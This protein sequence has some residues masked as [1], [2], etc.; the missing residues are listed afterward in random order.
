[1]SKGDHGFKKKPKGASGGGYA[2]PRVQIG[3]DKVTRNIITTWAKQNNRSFAS[4]VREL[5]NIG[6]KVR[7]IANP[8]A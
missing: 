6:L 5:V 4:E 7:S 3:F 8:L 2:R 1:M